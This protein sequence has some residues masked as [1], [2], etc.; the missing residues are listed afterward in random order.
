MTP[1]LDDVDAE[2]GVNPGQDQ[3][4]DESRQEELENGHRST[5]AHL[6]RQ[7]VGQQLHVVVEERDVVTRLRDAADGRDEGEKLRSGLRAI[8]ART[9]LVEVRL[10]EDDGDLLLPA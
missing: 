9:S 2:V 8:G 5:S 7:G 10:H 4:R 1:A 6:A 3:A